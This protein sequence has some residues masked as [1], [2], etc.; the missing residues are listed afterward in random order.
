MKGGLSPCRSYGAWIEQV[1]KQVAPTALA[2]S[3]TQFVYLACLAGQTLCCLCFL[4]SGFF[5]FECD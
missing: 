5:F 3:D 2:D 1:Y 4:L